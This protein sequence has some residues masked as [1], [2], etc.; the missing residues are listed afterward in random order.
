MKPLRYTLVSDGSSD[1]SLLPILSWLLKDCG[2]P[3]PVDPQWYDPRSF[4]NPPSS[5]SRRIDKAVQLYECDL[6]FVHR[7]AE[8]GSIDE[9]KQEIQ[10]AVTQSGKP[11]PGVCVVPVRMTE[12]WL[13]FDEKA[14]RNAAGNPN[15][16]SRVILPALKRLED[17]PD[18]KE[19]L[20]QLLRDASEL[21]GRRLR[22]FNPNRAVH[23]VANF[24]ED[25]S[26]LRSLSA[27][28]HL[29]EELLE[30]LN[31]GPWLS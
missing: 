16:K 11:V 7:D 31:S 29:E 15:G 14:I 25:F 13:L 23:D 5:L 28:Q 26:P 21:T 30:V 27:F 18:P 20:Y 4:P 9:R 12:A 3:G 19:V 2:V 1:S 24:I 10:E 17:L 8:R 22:K 6:L